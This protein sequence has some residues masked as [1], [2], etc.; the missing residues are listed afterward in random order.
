MK[1]E[2]MPR[3]LLIVLV[4]ACVVFLG[5]PLLALLVGALGL[6]LAFGGV[7]LKLGLIVLAAYGLAMLLRGGSTSAARASALSPAGGASLAD[8]AEEREREDRE[9]LAALDRELEQAIQARKA[10]GPPTT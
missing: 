4:V 5:P 1:Q 6:A 9:R 8:F 3:W 7:A 2:R 10:G